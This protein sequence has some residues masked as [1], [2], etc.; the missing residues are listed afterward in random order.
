MGLE[1]DSA[2]SA[3][4]GEQRALRQERTIF[5]AKN[6]FGGAIEAGNQVRS[7]LIVAGEHGGAEI[8]QLDHCARGCHL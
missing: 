4:T 5:E 8:A 2:Y 3:H 7:G 6:D 1:T